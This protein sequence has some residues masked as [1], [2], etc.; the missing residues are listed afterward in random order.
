L[1]KSLVLNSPAEKLLNI[2]FVC[3]ILW[4][5][6]EVQDVLGHLRIIYNAGFHSPAGCYFSSEERSSQMNVLAIHTNF[7][8][9]LAFLLYVLMMMS[10]G[11]I[12]VRFSSRG[13]GEFFLGGRQMKSFVVALSA[14]TSGRSAWL[15]IGVSGLAFTR[16]V[17]AVWAV[18]GYIVVELFMFVFPGKRLRYF[19]GKMGDITIP[20]Y[21]ESRFE[22]SKHLLRLFSLIPILIF[23]TAYVSAQFNAGGKSLAA[24]FNITSFQGILITAAIVIFYTVLGGFVAVCWTDMLQGLFMIF[25]LMILPIIAIIHFGGI[26][27][28]LST[29]GNVSPGYIDTFSISI[30]ALISYLGIGF[31]SPGNPHILNKY[32]SIENPEKLNKTGLIGTIW[33][34]L[35]AWGAVFI[36]LA[37]RAIYQD[38]AN[39]PNKDPE[40]VY[41]LLGSQQLHPFVFG[42]TIAAIF[43]AIMSTASSQLLVASS[44]VVRDFYQKIMAK[45]KNIPEKRLVLISRAV[46]FLVA[47]VALIFAAYANKLVFYLVLFAWGGLGAAFGPSLLLSLYWK[48]TSR[49][50]VIAGILVGSLTEIIWYL[51]PSLKS[52]VSEWVPAFILSFLA[53]VIVSFLTQPPQR[54]EEFMEFMKGK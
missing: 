3:V 14:V 46:T 40:N 15:L 5:L 49:E 34:V 4:L 54:T 32:M 16:G 9:L 2:I 25:A 6:R 26:G 52:I 30:G 19:T 28:L 12:T 18:V 43:A 22:D 7:W 36:G 8:S 31:G 13:L 10:V 33:N 24:S 11:I 50:A 45:G 27:K 20:D 1:K 41:P 44:A 47:L 21:M 35:M 39:L 51:I 48:K 29:L 53:V 37:G 42:L 17:S 23:M 38:V